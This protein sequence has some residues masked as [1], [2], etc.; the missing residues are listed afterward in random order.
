MCVRRFCNEGCVGLLLCSLR[1]S[2]KGFLSIDRT[3][4]GLTG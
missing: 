1:I 4:N 2:G 3:L